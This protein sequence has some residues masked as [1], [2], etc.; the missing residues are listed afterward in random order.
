MSVCAD[1]KLLTKWVFQAVETDQ[2]TGDGE[3][4]FVDVV[5]P[6]ITQFQMTILMQPTLCTFDDPAVNVQAT[7]VRRVA[8]GQQRARTSGPELPSVRLGIVAAI[9]LHPI[10]PM[11]RTP[12][13]ASDARHRVHQRQQL[14]H[15]VAV[16]LRE[17][18][19]HDRASVAVHEQVVFGAALAPIDRIWACFFPPCSARIDAESTTARDQSILSAALSLSSS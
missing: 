4:R 16:G 5:T 10:K 2:R 17:D 18:E 11:T 13:F 6:I 14:G 9:S 7:A 8:L 1:L 19:R 3:E 15:I 12:T